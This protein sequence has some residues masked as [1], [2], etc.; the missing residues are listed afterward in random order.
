MNIDTIYGTIKVNNP[1]IIRLLNSQGLS[2]LQN[3]LQHGTPDLIGM[4]KPTVTR[5]D[6]CIGAMV[7]VSKAGGSIDEQIAALLHD[8][9]HSAFSHIIDL[10]F[11]DSLQTG[12]SY[13][14]INMLKIISQTDIPDILGNNWIK[15]FDE[16]HFPLLERPSHQLSAD[17]GD[18]VP[19]DMLYNT[20]NTLVDERWIK[21]YANSI[22]SINGTHYSFI[23]K[24]LNINDMVFEDITFHRLE[25]KEGLLLC[26]LLGHLNAH[27]VKGNKLSH[28]ISV[29]RIAN[30]A[31]TQVIRGSFRGIYQDN[32]KQ[33]KKH[34][35]YS[36][37][38]VNGGNG[39]RSFGPN[40]IIL[41]KMGKYTYG[42]LDKSH[43]MAYVVT[44][45]AYNEILMI[46]QEAKHQKIIT[47]EYYNELIKKTIPRSEIFDYF[48]SHKVPIN[49]HQF[50]EFLQHRAINYVETI[51]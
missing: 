47:K 12:E 39:S 34:V 31:I 10:V 27:G 1:I 41:E 23:Y 43:Q 2:R 30:I 42:D 49:K 36:K 6:H 50:R 38:E 33:I 46:F 24:I 25:D 48:K 14:E 51:Q 29:V 20:K 32:T 19:R 5:Y 26:D 3:V 8:A 17:R 28:D 40:W 37:L 44:D 4:F 18:Y 11:K 9:S 7:L 16:Q 15:Y 22:I 13:H 21:K 45:Q 35:F